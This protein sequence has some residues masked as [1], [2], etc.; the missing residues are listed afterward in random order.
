VDD[1]I[2]TETNKK[3]IK[4]QNLFKFIFTNYHIIYKKGWIA[5]LI[6]FKEPIPEFLKVVS[7]KE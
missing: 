3:T 7:I 4:F 1:P 6:C 2:I 5:Q